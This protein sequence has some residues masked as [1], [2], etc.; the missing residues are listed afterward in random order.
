MPKSPFTLAFDH[1]DDCPDC[2][3]WARRLC[4]TGR[5]LFVAAYK[6]AQ[7]IAGDEVPTAKAQA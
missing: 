3:Y 4:Q 1:Y 5:A 6:A 7:L 2:D